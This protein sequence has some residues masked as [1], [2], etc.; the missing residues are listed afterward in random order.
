MK[1]LRNCIIALLISPF[2][3]LLIWVGMVVALYQRRKEV[4]LLRQ[5]LPGLACAIN[6]DCPS[7]FVCVS[8]RCVPDK[9]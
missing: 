9:A 5:A 1:H 2:T 3:P 8:G 7:G 4:N 6:T